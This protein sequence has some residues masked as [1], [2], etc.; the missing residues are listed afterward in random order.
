MGRR[1]PHRRR[2][3]RDGGPRAARRLPPARLPPRRRRAATSS[4]TPPGPSCSPRASRWSPTPTTS[5]TSRCSA[6]RSRTP[7]FGVEVPVAR[8]RARRPREGHRHRH[9]LH[10]RRHHR[11][12]LVARA[13]P[14][15]PG[16]R[17]GATAASPPTTPD[18]ITHRRRPRRATRELA[19]R[20]VKQAQARD[21]RAARRVGRAA[22]RAPA[23][24]PPGEV[25][26]AGRSR[27]L[28]IVTTRQWY[29]RNGGRDEALRERAPRARAASC[30]GTPTYM[31]H[32]YENWVGGLNGDWLI[33]RQRFFGVPIPLW[34]PLDADGELDHDHPIVPDEAALPDRPVHRRARRATPT[35]QRGQPGGF[36]GDPD[37]M[38]TW[39]TSSLTPA[40]RRRLGRRPRPVR[41]GSSRWTCARRP[42]TSSAPGC[43]PPSC[44]PHYEHGIAAV[45]ATPRSA[46]WIL[47]PDRKKMSKSKGN[48]VTPMALLEQYGT[49]AV[50][51]WAASGRP[52]VDTAFDEGQMKIGRK[53]ATKLLNVTKFVLGIR[54]ARRRTPAITEPLDRAMLAR[55]ADVVD[56]ATTGVRGARLRPGPRAHRGVL[57][58][59]LRRL[60]R[61]GQ[62]PGLRRTRRRRPPARP[63]PR[64]ASPS[65][66]CSGCSP[67]SCR[68]SPRRCGA[69]GRRARSTS[70]AWPTADERGAERAG[71][72]G[73][74]R[75]RR[76]GAGPRPPGQ[77]RG[78]AVPAVRRSTGCR[79][80]APPTSCP[81]SA[82]ARTTCGR[83]AGSPPST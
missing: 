7:L 48:V 12:H 18:W 8:P 15:D 46:G 19:G 33:S 21:R 13:R 23:D 28:E 68:S 39:A 54:R 6:P 35:T 26:R 11:R 58:V 37:V 3:G 40:D 62:G 29:I 79:W 25:L 64:S 76:R 71:R 51:Y 1:R 66:R 34:Y 47:D 44:A 81:P 31:R 65:T 50:R 80:P 77:D 72:P 30:A 17:S 36:V 43:S 53:L 78:Q 56:E 69:G 83:P 10:V 42:T 24:H 38:D 55:L 4:S 9:D 2:P 59:V 5:A 67:R 70:R 74:A 63:A 41:A 22:R 27:P 73:G 32:R 14:A 60:R 52:G 16:R 61:A 20:T 45:D 49:D 75:R 82:S 57:L